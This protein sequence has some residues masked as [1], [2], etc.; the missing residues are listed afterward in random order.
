MAA[1]RLTLNDFEVGEIYEHVLNGDYVLVIGKGNEQV[2]V[3]TKQF[4]EVYVFP[5]ELRPVE[6]RFDGNNG[7]YNNDRGGRGGNGGWNNNRGRNR[8]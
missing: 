7:Y 1:N 3:R 2:K 5:Y 8:W 6:Q 4:Q